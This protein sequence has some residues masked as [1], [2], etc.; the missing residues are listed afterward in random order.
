MRSLRAFVSVIAAFH[1]Y[2]NDHIEDEIN[3]AG[4]GAVQYRS[5]PSQLCSLLSIFPIDP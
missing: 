3:D 4:D 2:G 1:A 5:V